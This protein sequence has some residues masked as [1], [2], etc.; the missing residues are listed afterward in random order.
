M[1][2]FIRMAMAFEWKIIEKKLTDG[3]S[4][5]FAEHLVKIVLCPN[6]RDVSHWIKELYDKCFWIHDIRIKPKN[7]R[8]TKKDIDDYYF[9][10]CNDIA[11]FKDKCKKIRKLYTTNIDESNENEI[12]NNKVMPFIDEVENKLIAKKPFMREDLNESVNN[13]LLK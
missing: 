5:E 13:H 6:Y 2:N 9:G 3:R 4:D 10:T 1:T 12:F 8:L 7:K 11:S